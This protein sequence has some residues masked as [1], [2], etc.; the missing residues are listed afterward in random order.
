MEPVFHRIE[1][2][3]QEQFQAHIASRYGVEISVTTE[4]PK[5][6]GFGELAIP[7]AFQLAKQLKQ[8]PRKIATELID[9][10]GPIPGVAAA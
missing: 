4:Q 2:Q 9:E 7:V 10:I 6:S 5:Q 3:V 8:A 1:K